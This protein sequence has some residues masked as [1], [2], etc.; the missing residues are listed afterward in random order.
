MQ[1]F[2]RDRRSRGNHSYCL[3]M[4]PRHTLP[5]FVPLRE[6]YNEALV[7][8]IKA[9]RNSHVRDQKRR[10]SDCL[11]QTAPGTKRTTV[12]EGHSDTGMTGSKSTGGVRCPAGLKQT[13]HQHI[14]FA[15]TYANTD[16]DTRSVFRGAPFSA[17]KSRLRQFRQEKR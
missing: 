14:S 12:P 1:Y 2:G 16:K 7:H 5:E 9:T 10:K 3:S 17:D 6:T 4:W 15:R 11:L 8:L 13:M